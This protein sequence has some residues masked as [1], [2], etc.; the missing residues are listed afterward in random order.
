MAN[1]EIQQTVELW[2]LARWLTGSLN[3][4]RVELGGSVARQINPAASCPPG[5][6]LRWA[7]LRPVEET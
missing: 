4:V 6:G 5:G 1:E 2:V 7:H 3:R